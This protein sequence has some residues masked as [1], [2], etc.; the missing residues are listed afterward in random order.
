MKKLDV[1]VFCWIW[2]LLG[3]V[4]RASAIFTKCRSRFTRTRITRITR[5]H[6][7]DSVSPACGWNSEFNFVGISTKVYQISL[8]TSLPGL[9]IESNSTESRNH[10]RHDRHGKWQGQRSH[11]HLCVV[12]KYVICMYMSYIDL[13][14]M[15]YYDVLLCMYYYARITMYAVLL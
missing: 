2:M 3:H 11:L 6:D 8:T 10:G 5:I 1:W 15:Y 9:P 4:G 14:S 13:L 7:S 12:N